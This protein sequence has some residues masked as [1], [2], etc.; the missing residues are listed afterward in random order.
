ME[1]TGACFDAPQ[2]KNAI[3][4]AS[5]SS[6][7]KC[8]AG[9]MRVHILSNGFCQECN[10]ELAWKNGD[11]VQREQVDKARRIALYEKGKKHIARKWKEKYGND[12][13]DTVLG[14]R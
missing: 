13:A 6:C 8:R 3:S 7:K 10:E 1:S 5:M 9:A 2:S 14:Y 4:E 12:D 11:R